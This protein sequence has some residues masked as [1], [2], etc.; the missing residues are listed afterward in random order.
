MG[1]EVV[2]VDA[3]R[4]PIGRYKGALKEVRPDDLAAV[5]I[6]ALIERN[7]NVPVEQIDDVVFG[8]ANQAGEDNRNVARMAALLAG[9]PIEVAGVTVNRLCGSG[10]DAVNYAARAILANEADIMIAGG[11]E[12]MTR[13]PFV[14]AKPSSDFPRG[15]IEMYDTTIGWR[16][17]NPKM[18]E[19]YGTDSM[20]QTAEN[21]AKRFGITREAQDEF[22]YES[23]MK[24]KQAIETNRFADELV[25][26]VYH[27]RKGNRVVVDKDEHPRPDTTL[28]KLAKLPPLFENG[29]V[30]AGNSS[31][32]NDGAAA[33]LVMSAEKA[34]ELGLK[35]LAV[36]VTSAVAG[37]EPAVMGIGPIFA[38]RKA[39]RRAG[40]SLDDI[41]LVELN[42]AFASQALECIRQLELDRAKVNVNGGAIAL[43]HPLGASGARILTTLI[44]EMRKRGV[45][46]GLATMCIGVGQGIATIVKNADER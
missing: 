26:V 15:N 18:H 38:T 17:I 11:V 42:E 13:A 23:Q 7:P 1:R 20:P 39:L 21:V 37:V 12:S 2:I 8:N 30:T 35:P 5:V 28:E 41:G 9:L 46:Y 22:A 43:G 24:A 45:T 32:V 27:D 33:L 29:T 14:M 6:R 3:V 44:Y 10:L 4:T 19:M 25:P 34:K 40:L 16:F 36:Y 31:G